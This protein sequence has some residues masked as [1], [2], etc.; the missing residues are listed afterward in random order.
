MSLTSTPP[1]RLGLTAAAAATL[2]GMR[3]AMRLVLFLGRHLEYGHLIVH[4]DGVGTVRLD[5]RQAGATAELT[6]HNQRMARRL[7]TQGGLGFAESYLDGDWST[8]D[9]SGLLALANR[10]DQ[11]IENV[12]AG[13]PWIQAA[14]RLGH[15]MR[16]NSRRGSRRNIAF[17]YDLGNP[18]YAAWLDPG[19]TYSAAM[20]AQPDE[21]LMPA[22][23][24]KFDHLAN[25][26]ALAPDDHLLEIGCGWGGF[27]EHVAR[28]R[29]C[30]VTAV[31]ISEQ[32]YAYARQRIFAA[33]LAEKVDI[34]LQDYRD[35]GGQFDKVASIEM[36]EAVGERYWPVFFDK[37]AAVL[38][39]GGLAGLQVITI[40]DRYFETYRRGV[41]FIQRYVF[42]GGMLPSPSVFAARAAQAGLKQGATVCFGQDYAVTVDRW[43]QCFSDRWATIEPLGFDERFRRLWNYYLSYCEA[44]FRTGSIDVMQT[45]L[46]RG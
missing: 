21:A 9:L 10:N 44:G 25:T 11:F 26:I 45:V 2:P 14:R 16:G 31:T 28:T 30:R 37:L 33:G 34:R 1:Q 17:H 15:A 29:G 24:R 4:V 5:G 46:S 8:G 3:R 22:Q 35:I 32:Q 38:K 41:D 42:P 13:Q 40:D 43:R 23:A 39:P 20:F 27:A 18:F 12:M 7:V 36:F 19:M 6:V